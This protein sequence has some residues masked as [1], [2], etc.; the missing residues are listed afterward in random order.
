MLRGLRGDFQLFHRTYHRHRS[1]R[2]ALAAF[3]LQPSTEALLLMRMAS[4]GPKVISLIAR[5]RLLRRFS[6]DVERGASIAPGL[7]VAHALGIV[8]GGGTRT[9]HNVKLH[10]NVTLG[11]DRGGWPTLEEDVMVFP[12]A[13][14][15]GPVTIGRGANIGANAFVSADVPAGTV[16][17]GG[18]RWT[19]TVA[20][21]Q[22]PPGS[23][24]RREA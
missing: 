14:V 2:M 11:V 8:L 10:H 13:V 1:R 9:A 16:V 7:L 5:R 19:R 23:L 3:W 18:T 15:V 4:T 12:G 21:A 17:P 24:R 22:D 6:T 20:A